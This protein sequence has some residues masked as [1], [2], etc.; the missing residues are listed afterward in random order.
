M[1]KYLDYGSYRLSNVEI[2]L[3]DR[4]T[5]H[6]FSSLTPDPISDIFRGPCTPIMICISYRTYEIVYCSLFLSFHNPIL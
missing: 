6:A 2:G 5:R 1:I 4:S 3:C